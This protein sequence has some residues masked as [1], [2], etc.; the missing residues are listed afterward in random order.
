MYR[1][2]HPKTVEETFL[3]SA[4]GIFSR[5]EHVLGHK[6]NLHKLKIEIPSKV[7]SDHNAVKLENDYK[8]KDEGKKSQICKSKQHTTEQLLA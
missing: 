5:I 1:I 6:T 4:H 3:S 2:F 7:F 8:K